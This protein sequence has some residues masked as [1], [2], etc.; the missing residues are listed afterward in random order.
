MLGE[1][2]VR[3]VVACMHISKYL[4]RLGGLAVNSAWPG[5]GSGG[6]AGA[7]ELQP[8]TAAVPAIVSKSG[9]GLIFRNTDVAQELLK[10][11]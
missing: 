1:M 4:G 7:P 9:G 11:D 5:W 3:F 6:S 2:G 8:T 10:S